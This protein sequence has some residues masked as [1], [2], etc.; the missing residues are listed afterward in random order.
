MGSFLGLYKIKV[1]I[2]IPVKNVIGIFVG[3]ALNI[4]IILGSVGILTLF[5]LWRTLDLGFT[6][7]L[8]VKANDLSKMTPSFCI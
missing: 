4:Q 5:L 6:W 2:F 1:F 8:Y 3:I 7:R